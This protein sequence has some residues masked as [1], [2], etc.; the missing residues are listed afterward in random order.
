MVQIKQCAG[1]RGPKLQTGLTV[2]GI[3]FLMLVGAFVLT[4]GFKLGPVYLDNA[5]IREAIE[6]LEE[7]NF[8]EM[9]DRQ[10]LTHLERT[11][12]I[13]NI[14]DVNP[15]D[16]KISRE[17]HRLLVAMDYERRINFMGNVD[18]VVK[19]ENH[20]DSSKQ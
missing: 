20:F 17:K 3:I 11:F 16:I 8:R 10:I 13:N 9:T 15:K 14:R 18:V 7:E 12:D 2:T 6:S 19:F 5:F 4:A 1:P